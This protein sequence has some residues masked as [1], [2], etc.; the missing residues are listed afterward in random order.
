MAQVFAGARAAFEN[1]NDRERKLVTLLGGVLAVLI[2]FLPVWLLTSSIGAIED[3]NEQ[4]RGALRDIS[5]HGAQLAARDEQRQAAERRYDNPAPPLGSFL[6]AKAREAGYDRPL[7]VTDQPEKVEGAFTRRNTRAS[8]PGV[9]LR[10]AVG[11]MTAIKNSPYPVA[12]EKLQLEHYQ[13]GDRYNVQLGVV[14]FDRNDGRRGGDSEGNAA[15]TKRR[16]GRPGPPP[17]P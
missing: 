1:L 3:E 16:G 12:I 10:T 2:V 4:I 7:E 8:L 14:A 13:A 11:V 9:D 15:P 6:E 5:D 17:P